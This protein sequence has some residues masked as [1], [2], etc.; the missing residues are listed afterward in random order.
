[1]NFDVIIFWILIMI[2]IEFWFIFW[3]NVQDL[4]TAIWTLTACRSSGRDSKNWPTSTAITRARVKTTAANLGARTPPP[5]PH[6]HFIHRQFI[7]KTWKQTD[8]KKKSL[9][10]EFQSIVTSRGGRKTK[11]Q[12]QFSQFLPCSSTIINQSLSVYLECDCWQFLGNFWYLFEHFF[13]PSSSS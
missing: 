4:T 1:M 6:I 2:L 7:M 9:L 5:P 13:S 11:P 3:L 10:I 12:K 8:K